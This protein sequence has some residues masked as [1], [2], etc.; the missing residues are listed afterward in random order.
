[1]AENQLPQHEVIDHAAIVDAVITFVP[2]A[3]AAFVDRGDGA[4]QLV[5]IDGQRAARISNA[6]AAMYMGVGPG[7][8]FEDDVRKNSGLIGSSFGPNLTLLENG[9]V[10][11]DIVRVIKSDAGTIVQFGRFAIASRKATEQDRETVSEHQVVVEVDHRAELEEAEATKT[12]FATHDHAIIQVDSNN[13]YLSFNAPF[14]IVV[15][16]VMEHLGTLPEGRTVT[17][18]QAARAVWNAMPLAERGIF[19]DD[20]KLAGGPAPIQK[21]VTDVLN[22]I[23]NPLGATRRGTGHYSVTAETIVVNLFATPPEDIPDRTRPVFVPGAPRDEVLPQ[24]TEITVMLPAAS[25]VLVLL[26][27][28]PGLSHVEAIGVLDVIMKLEG[29]IALADLSA[30][31]GSTESIEDLLDRLHTLVQ[32]TLG[33]TSYYEARRART[34]FG[35]HA[36]G[37][38]GVQQIGGGLDGARTKFVVG[39]FSDMSALRRQPKLSKSQRPPTLS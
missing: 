7:L 21:Y 20:N 34:P 28:K 17:I 5:L 8:H 39:K 15:A 19:C 10:P 6:L 4:E 22:K 23:T 27:T 12:N 31:Q 3:G 35:G 18:T 25:D 33:W 36:T 37:A 1:M 38:K 29:K 32:M 16:R 24:E 9:I 13:F 11:A 14:S 26:N 2:N 30:D